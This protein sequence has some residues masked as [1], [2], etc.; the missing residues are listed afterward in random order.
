MLKATVIIV[1]GVLMDTIKPLKN[2]VCEAYVPGEI[3]WMRAA[4]G[5][6]GAGPLSR[7]RF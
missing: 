1:V 6:R 2:R 3:C 7:D 5:A 4:R